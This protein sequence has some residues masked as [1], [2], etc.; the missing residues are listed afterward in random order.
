MPVRDGHMGGGVQNWEQMARAAAAKCDQLR[1]QVAQAEAN[2]LRAYRALERAH[3]ALGLEPGASTAVLP[4]V[5]VLRAHVAALRTALEATP[6]DFVC[7]GDHNDCAHAGG[8]RGAKDAWCLRCATLR[9]TQESE[10]R[11]G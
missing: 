11:E 5:P 3:A 7:R 9:D 4:S 2:E 10:G 1:A 8:G 6:C